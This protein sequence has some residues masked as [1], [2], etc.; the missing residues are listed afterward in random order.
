M[1]ALLVRSTIA[2]TTEISF[3]PSIAHQQ[4]QPLISGNARSGVVSFLSR[5]IREHLLASHHRSATP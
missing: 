1:L 5:A 2:F 3:N 4:K